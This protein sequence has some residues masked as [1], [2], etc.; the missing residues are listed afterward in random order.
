M[1][2]PESRTA[3]ASGGA[4]IIFGALGAALLWRWRRGRRARLDAYI[5]PA[6]LDRAAQNGF[7]ASPTRPQRGA[8]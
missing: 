6:R 2:A 4:L 3:L 7:F 5:H 8:D 1:P